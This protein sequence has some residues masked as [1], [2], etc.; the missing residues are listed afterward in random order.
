MAEGTAYLDVV[1][2][3]GSSS[4]F[5]LREHAVLVGRSDACDLQLCDPCVSREHARIVFR[6]GRWVTGICGLRTRLS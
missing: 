2:P 5:V 1:E 6:D 4:K 3:D